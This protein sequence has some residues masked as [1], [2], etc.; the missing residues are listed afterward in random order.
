MDASHAAVKRRTIEVECH[1]LEAELLR[2]RFAGS[3]LVS[4]HPVVAGGTGTGPSPGELVQMALASATV[5]AGERFADRTGL[6]L[7]RLGARTS[8]AMTREGFPAELQQ[9]PLRRLVYIDSIARL[10]EAEGPLDDG[11][12]AVLAEAMA[13]NR[14]ARTLRA[15]IALDEC[16]ECVT[17]GRRLPPLPKNP[18]HLTDRAR[19]RT[20][21]G[22]RHVA[23]PGGWRVSAASLGAGACLV[24]AGGGASVVG[25]GLGPTPEELL[26]AGLAGC[27]TI[28]LARNAA[29]LEIPVE[30]VR[31]VVRAELPEDP[32]AP[33]AAMEKVAWVAGDLMPGELADLE[34]VARYCAIGESLNRGAP[35]ADTLA[36][37]RAQIAAGLSP[38]AAL[39]RSDAPAPPAGAACDDGICCVP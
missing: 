19:E 34:V 2:V 5:L 23:D 11:Q 29:L 30:S 21:P 38:L 18:F 22:E 37:R 10:I 27:T 12:A 16:L 15:G 6:G 28:F 36:I 7:A 39:A 26:L 1:Y 32:D 31:V 8:L 17:T 20:A 25:A 3:Q 13:E 33:I 4:D 24:Q 14:V 35:I 9:G